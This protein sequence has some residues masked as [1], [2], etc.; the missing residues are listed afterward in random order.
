MKFKTCT[1]TLVI[2]YFG[3]YI[4]ACISSDI[5][6]LQIYNIYRQKY[7][8]RFFNFLLQYWPKVSFLNYFSKNL[9]LK[10]KN[11]TML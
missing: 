1:I 3:S 4:K 2:Y 5:N 7:K 6:Y 8:I 10:S 9:L 11:L